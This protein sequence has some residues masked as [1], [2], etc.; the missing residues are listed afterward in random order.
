MALLRLSPFCCVW[1][2]FPWRPH[3]S[4]GRQSK[5]YCPCFIKQLNW[6]ASP[7]RWTWVQAGSGSWWWKGKPG[8]LQSMRSQEV[9]HDWQTEMSGKAGRWSNFP[10]LLQGSHRCWETQ[11]F[12]AQGLKPHGLGQSS[13]LAV[14]PWTRYLSPCVWVSSYVNRGHNRHLLHSVMMNALIYAIINSLVSH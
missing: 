6:M 12:C 5:Y 9:R 14:W 11:R 8:V 10:K 3:S 2:S 4:L 13:V 7:T 1:E